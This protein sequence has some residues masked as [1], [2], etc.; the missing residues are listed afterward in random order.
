MPV[1]LFASLIVRTMAYA[2]STG[3]IFSNCLSDLR[4]C[5][6]CP[7]GP[8]SLPHIIACPGLLVPLRDS[9]NA[10]LAA[11][12]VNFSIPELDLSNKV[13][14]FSCLLPS[15]PTSAAHLMFMAGA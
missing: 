7:Y 11:K 13:N 10:L 12:A 4:S 3:V 9:L 2:W 6:F 14:L 5:P 1:L 15:V 8:E